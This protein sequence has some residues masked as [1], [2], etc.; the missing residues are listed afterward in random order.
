MTSST[1]TPETRTVAA[2]WRRWRWPVRVIVV[3]LL[4]ALLIGFINSQNRRGF[5]D[6][7]GVDHTGSGAAAALLDNLGVEVSEAR[8]TSEVVRDAGQDTTVLITI[9]DLLQQDQV[10]Q[11]LGTHADLVLV[12]P[13]LSLTVFDPQLSLAGED[14]PSSR[15]PGC[16]L[17]EAV[18]A[19]S[20]RLG[21][22]YT[23]GPPATTC[24]D[25]GL[26]VTTLDSG[27]RLV[28]FGSSDL[29]T[30]RYLDED[31]NA[32]LVLGLLGHHAN[33]IWYRPVPETDAA[34][35]T[36]LPE[37]LPEWVQPVAWQLLVAAVFAAWWRGRRLGRVVTEPLPVVV[38]AAETTE[39]RAR[40]YRRGRARGHAAATLRE[41]TA[42]R[43]QQR[44]S[45]PVDAGITALSEAVA[46]RTGRSPSDV[47]TLLGGPEPRDDAALVRLAD[48]LDALEM[49]VRNRDRTDH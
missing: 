39:G 47:A 26:V 36:P 22:E 34:E 8:R 43:L 7:Q 33:L 6:P 3:L 46:A 32:A 10:D 24:Y 17:A 27:Q 29:L 49:E 41:A 25:G 15:E 23:G 2:Y 13:T 19:G 1:L 9:P 42:A 45:Q 4:T 11:L 14:L 12:A 16:E 35:A 40:L 37:L 31:G 18:R 21:A 44:L 30:N 28:V 5:L 38:R 20:A 48:E